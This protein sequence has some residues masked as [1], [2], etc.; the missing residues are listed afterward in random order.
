MLFALDRRF[1]FLPHKN[2]ELY[3][4]GMIKICHG[5]SMESNLLGYKFV[6]PSVQKLSDINKAL[7]RS[8]LLRVNLAIYWPWNYSI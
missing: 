2:R 1:F 7:E 8:Y 5:F 3:Y 6:S 4:I